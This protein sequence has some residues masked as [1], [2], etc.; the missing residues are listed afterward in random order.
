MNITETFSPHCNVAIANM[1]WETPQVND[2]SNVAS[3]ASAKHAYL[4]EQSCA[5]PLVSQLR[6]PQS[7]DGM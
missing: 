2:V 7:N 6:L 3:L 5:N 4:T 1:Q